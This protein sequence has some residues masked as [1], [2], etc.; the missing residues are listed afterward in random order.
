M[1]KFLALLVLSTAL[2]ANNIIIKS[3]EYSVNE[4]IENIKNIVTAKGLTVF[5]VIDH[6]ANAKGVE[7]VLNESK[8]IIF[9]NPK[10]GTLLMQ[11]EALVGLDLPLR[12]LVY[13]DQDSAVKMA[14][15]EGT[16]IKENHSIEKDILIKKVNQGMDK[17]SDKAGVK[18]HK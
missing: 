1:K 15:R 3:S 11:E 16:W 2:F 17:I 18:V 10:L 13:K 14:Y 7:L 9:G 8:L 6:K 4:T 5:S 12:I